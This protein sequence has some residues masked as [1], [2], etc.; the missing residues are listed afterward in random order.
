M[1]EYFSGITF[2]QQKVTPSDDASV[3]RAVL[4]DGI[5]S[6]CAISYVGST[7]T[8]GPGL[9]IG[10]GREFRHTAMQNF[11]VTGAASGFARLVVTI[12]T[13]LASTKDSFEQITA[14]IEYA[15]A[16]DGFQQLQQDDINEDGTVY[17]MEICVIS[18]TSGGISGIVSQI[19]AAESGGTS[20][21]VLLW[22]N[23]SPT[24]AFAEQ[25]IALDLSK[26]DLV[27]VQFLR[28]NST[29]AMRVNSAIIGVGDSGCL[30]DLMTSASAVPTVMMRT[31]EMSDSGIT[32]GGALTQLTNKTERT[33]SPTYCIPIRIYGIKGVIS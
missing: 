19:G 18:L 33:V 7:L 12:D 22:E 9:L 23:A 15:T 14:S 2:P 27:M 6:G 1:S 20:P 30:I 8:F 29:T 3:R 32:F 16:Q 31:F 25:T 28:V 10:C 21:V 26:Y 5:L 24:S 17:Q 13:T 11:A 4:A